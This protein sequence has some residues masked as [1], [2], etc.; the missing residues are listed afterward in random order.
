MT[1]LRRAPTLLVMAGG[2]TCVTGHIFPWGK[3]D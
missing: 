1:L 3:Y 2:L